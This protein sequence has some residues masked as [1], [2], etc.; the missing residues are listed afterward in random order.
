MVLMFLYLPSPWIWI[1][2]NPQSKVRGIWLAIFVRH[3]AMPVKGMYVSFV[4]YYINVVDILTESGVDKYLQIFE[5]W[6]LCCFLFNRF[7]R[8]TSFTRK[9]QWQPLKASKASCR[10]STLSHWWLRIIFQW[11]I[12]QPFKVVFGASDPL[13]LYLVFFCFFSETPT[14]RKITIWHTLGDFSFN[15]CG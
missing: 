4:G 11:L 14:F 8:V 3:S 7:N 9:V 10:Y 5:N 6:C 13:V 1:F 15:F 2:F 12:N